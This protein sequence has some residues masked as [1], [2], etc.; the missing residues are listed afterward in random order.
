MWYF[1]IGC[2]RCNWDSLSGYQGGFKK[3]E[4]VRGGTSDIYWGGIDPKPAD[5]IWIDAR[6]NNQQWG[7]PV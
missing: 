4:V 2:L 1:I 3:V 6:S 5:D 7:V